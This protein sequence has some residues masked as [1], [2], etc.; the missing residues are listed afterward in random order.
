[1]AAAI[2]RLLTDPTLAARLARG[3]R[4]RVESGFSSQVRLDR[5]EA[6]YERLIAE[7]ATGGASAGATPAGT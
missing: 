5:I 6:L 2:R 1:M 4:E 7:R 3:G